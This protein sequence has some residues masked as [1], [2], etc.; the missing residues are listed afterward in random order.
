[1]G[2]E[3]GRRSVRTLFVGFEVV[4]QKSK[5]IPDNSIAQHISK[6]LGQVCILISTAGAADDAGIGM[7]G[8]VRR[9]AATVNARGVKARKRAGK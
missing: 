6:E 5:I 3:F 8:G 4:N 2:L 7:T 1:M 9:D